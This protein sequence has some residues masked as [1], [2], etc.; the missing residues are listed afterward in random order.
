MEAFLGR[1]LSRYGYRIV[2]SR[3]KK[4]KTNLADFVLALL[5]TSMSVYNAFGSIND[6]EI[7]DQNNNISMAVL[8]TL[9]LIATNIILLIRLHIKHKLRFSAEIENVSDWLQDCWRYDD[10]IDYGINLRISI[11]EF[12]YLLDALILIFIWRYEGSIVDAIAAIA[13][14][15][16]LITFFDDVIEII[17]NT[18]TIRVKIG[19]VKCVEK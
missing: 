5:Y 16:A 18:Y 3:T 9:F 6:F 13:L 12:G 8:P 1:I 7:R 15:S 4:W 19:L 11:I 14:V 17:F 10:I 2:D